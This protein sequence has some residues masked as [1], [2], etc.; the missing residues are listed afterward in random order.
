MANGAALAVPCLFPCRGRKDTDDDT[1]K[2]GL[3]KLKSIILYQKKAG[4]HT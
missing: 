4:M 2:E 3:A 1:V